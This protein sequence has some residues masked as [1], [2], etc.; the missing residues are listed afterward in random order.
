[1]LDVVETT[2]ERDRAES[3][4]SSARD[5]RPCRVLYRFLGTVPA[6]SG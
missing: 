5:H 4:D 2:S 3:L 1:M 6:S